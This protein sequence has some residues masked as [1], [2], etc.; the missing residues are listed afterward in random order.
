MRI[1][2]RS[3]CSL[4]CLLCLLLL[5]LMCGLTGCSNSAT[6]GSTTIT[7]RF[8]VATIPPFRI[9]PVTVSCK[10]GEQMLSGGWGVTAPCIGYLAHLF[11]KR[12]T[13]PL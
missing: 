2:V 3:W 1:S 13:W 6:G 5:L 12:R 7:D 8:A 10:L 4:L 9:V 11:K